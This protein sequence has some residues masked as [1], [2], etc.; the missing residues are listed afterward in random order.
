[1]SIDD[2]LDDGKPE[3]GAFLAAGRAG[4]QLLERAE[5]QLAVLFR[6]AR[7][8]V[9][10]AEGEAAVVRPQRDP[11]RRAGW[12]EFDCVADEV[13]NDLVEARAVDRRALSVGS[14][15]RHCDLLALRMR[16]QMPDAA[17]DHLHEVVIGT[18]EH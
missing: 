8:L 10:D 6:D 15:D 1:M 18:L 17:L 2:F 3:A 11:Y 7:P 12:R 13:I 16:F 9:L 14:V 5:K 4:A